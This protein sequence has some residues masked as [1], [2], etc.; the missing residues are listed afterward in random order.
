INDAIAEIGGQ[1]VRA[2]WSRF[3]GLAQAREVNIRSMLASE[4]E[5]AATLPDTVAEALRARSEPPEEIAP[6][7]ASAYRERIAGRPGREEALIVRACGLDLPDHERVELANLLERWGYAARIGAVIDDALVQRQGSA[8]AA[9]LQVIGLHARGAD[10]D[11]LDPA[12]GRLFDRVDSLE[13]RMDAARLALELGRF[14]R[15]RAAFQWLAADP[16]RRP[17][18]IAELAKLA[19]WSMRLDDAVVWAERLLEVDEDSALGWRV[20]GGALHLQGAHDAAREDLYRA[21][22]IDA[23]DNETKLWLAEV[24]HALQDPRAH[25]WIKDVHFGDVPVWQISRARVQA[26]R[27]GQGPKTWFILRHSLRQALGPEATLTERRDDPA[28]LPLLDA[29]MA[30]FGGNRTARLTFCDSPGSLRWADEVRS[31]RK[32]AEA[33][34]LTLARRRAEDV[35]ADFR[36]LERRHPDVPFFGTYAAEIELWMGRYEAA[37]ERFERLW[38][39]HQTRWGY[40]G[41]GACCAMLGR[42]AQALAYFDAGQSVYSFLPAEA[43][44]CYRAEIWLRAGRFSEARADLDLVVEHRPSR[45]GGWL[46]R[47]RLGLKTNDGALVDAARRAV[48]RHCPALCVLV[49]RDAPW[50]DDP[51][52][53]TRFVDRSLMCLRGNRSSVLHTFFDG[54][55]MATVPVLP[56]EVLA[57]EGRAVL[58]YVRDALLRQRITGVGNAPKAQP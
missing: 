41:A 15:A 46:L 51:V 8:R 31:P 47:A 29:A 38:R 27:E 57:G 19:L 16:R 53:Q 52:E 26:A 1:Q 55:E 34:Q 39:D 35:L 43:T 22:R 37:L 56:K 44:Y 17:E 45:V 18:A 5:P 48:A 42:D 30:R 58:P 3:E 13:S 40:V 10:A 9:R 4:F 14:E 21:H 11:A 54:D 12:L 49:E 25:T 32:Q 50:S 7:L 33:L 36:A 24:C 6:L 2:L 28:S 20:R 23:G